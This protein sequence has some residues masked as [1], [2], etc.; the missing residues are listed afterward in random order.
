MSACIHACCVACGMGGWTWTACTVVFSVCRSFV[1]PALRNRFLYD[2][3]YYGMA[4]NQPQIIQ[5]A[6]G[7]S[8]TVYAVLWQNLVAASAGIPGVVLAIAVLP[9]LG[10]KALQAYG[11]VLLAVCC[12]AMAALNFALPDANTTHPT[13]NATTTLSATT[14]SRGGDG[15]SSTAA[16]IQFGLFCVLV[17]ALNFGPNVS[18]Y[19]LPP[20]SFPP[21]VR[22]SFFGLSAAMGKVGALFGGF[23]FEP[24]AVAFGYGWLFVIC[25]FVSVGGVVLT[26]F[27]VVPYNTRTF[28]PESHASQQQQESHGSTKGDNGGTSGH[29][30]ISTALLNAG[31][32]D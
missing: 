9:C 24:L 4:L 25:G 32:S 12:A 26:H 23:C 18:T 27:A 31:E 2:F 20:Q 16:W 10:A 7:T 19:V 3:L 6:F 5:N 15:A 1:L 30:E 14:A 8:D 22:S 11:F 21:A 28:V 17:F 13:T 29:R